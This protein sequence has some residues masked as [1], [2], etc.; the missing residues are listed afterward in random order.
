MSNTGQLGQTYS[1]ESLGVSYSAPEC[2]DCYICGNYGTNWGVMD[3]KI[4][5]LCDRHDAEYWRGETDWWNLIRLV[6]EANDN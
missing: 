3:N 2:T 6:R 4:I 5:W 1:I